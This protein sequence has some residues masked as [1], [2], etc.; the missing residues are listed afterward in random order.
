MTPQDRLAAL[1]AGT[2]PL[3]VARLKSG[4][5]V[6]AEN[7]FLPGYCLL[8]GD[9]ISPKLNDLTGDARTGF[10]LEMAQVGDVV[11]QV[12]GAAR[13]NYGIYGN[14]DPFVHAHIWP[15]FSDELAELR[16]LPPMG[17][18]AAVRESPDT[19]FSEE[20]HGDLLRR[21]RAAFAAA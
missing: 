12:T 9:P 11:L 8:L 17:F 1:H 20:I 7:Q 15:R 21:L 3:V 14:V 6:L 13:I 10:L 16:N 2:N 5:V 18:P 19:R 4:F